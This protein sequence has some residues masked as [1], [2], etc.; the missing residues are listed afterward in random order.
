MTVLSRRRR[1][2]LVA[3]GIAAIVIAANGSQGAYF[4]QSWGWV[5]LAFLVPTTLAL[6]L[7][8]VETP[9]RLRVAFAALVTTLG[10]WIALSALW[11]V[12][13][14]ASIRESERMLAYIAL[15]LALGLLARRGDARAIV[16][17]ALVGAVAISGY[18]LATRLFQHVFTPR[19][20]EWLPYRL[21]APIGYWNSLGLLAAFGL[22]LA[23][24][25][26]AQARNS[27]IVALAAATLPLFA[28]TLYFTFSRGAWVALATGLGAVVVVD[29]RRLRILSTVLAL[30]PPSAG[31]IALASRKSAL[32]SDGAGLEAA[33]EQ[34]RALAL[35]IVA[36]MVAS[37][38]LAICVQLAA[39]LL[40]ASP[41]TRRVVD[42]ALLVALAGT[43]SVALGLLG[44]PIAAA[45]ELQERVRSELTVR[46]SSDLN[47][48]LFSF[49]A[50]G[51]LEHLQVA[52]E[53]ALEQP[54]VGNGAGTYEIFWYLLRPIQ[55]DVRDA[56]SLYAEMLAELGI[57]GLAFLLVA[58][59]VPGVAAL[60]A[61]R[62]RLV[63]AALGV[64]VAWG[65]HSAL[66]WHWEVVGVTATAFL[67]GGACLLAAERRRGAILPGGVRLPT[68]VGTAAL[69][70]VAVVSLVGNQALFAAR[71]ARAR[72]EWETA[73]DHARRA[74]AL[75][76]WS[77]EPLIVRGDAAAGSGD[78]AGAHD[79]YRR[80]VAKDPRNWVAWLRLAQV[81]TG[82]ERTRAYARVRALNPLARNLPGETR[83][84][85]PS[86]P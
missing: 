66:D 27:L 18:A 60:R 63:P 15:A 39:R 29:P 48:R 49:S 7:G 53:A 62:A 25:F 21:A 51:R 76:P 20:E 75:L 41:R 84:P 71:E 10:V 1:S 9:G 14:S 82:R 54:V 26:A 34:G 13:P 52:W 11:S 68:L 56:H 65:V 28:C 78:R 30:A 36:F 31:A 45:S 33:V 50:N 6:I 83:S 69:S 59:A 19:G 43:I 2:A 77:V 35:W 46:D 5:A 16:G 74:Q 47:E 44:G 38:A 58:L 17:G 85:G 22:I 61:R 23:F 37:A 12:S 73:Y 8:V 72:G 70:A 55:L 57:V 24:G 3:L 80:A 86:T 79:A 42:L 64:Y 81:A 67:V 4:S 32:T 40:P